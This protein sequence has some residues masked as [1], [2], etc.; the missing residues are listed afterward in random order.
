LIIYK[1]IFSEP[2]K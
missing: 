2:N 1:S